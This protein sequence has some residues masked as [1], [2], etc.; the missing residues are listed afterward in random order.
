M[1]VAESATIDHSG[2]SATT[3]SDRA[4]QGDLDL[5]ERPLDAQ[6]GNLVR[7]VGIGCRARVAAAPLHVKVEPYGSVT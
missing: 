2:P 3:F 6:R 5:L 4:Q 7:R 1:A